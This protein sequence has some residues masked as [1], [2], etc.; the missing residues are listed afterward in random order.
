M[1]AYPPDPP[2]VTR[3]VVHRIGRD[4]EHLTCHGVTTLFN[5]ERGVFRT[6]WCSRCK[7]FFPVSEFK[8]LNG[9]P[10]K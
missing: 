4:Y 7:N 2:P 8:W 3:K 10:M 5:G 6:A 9:A 1:T